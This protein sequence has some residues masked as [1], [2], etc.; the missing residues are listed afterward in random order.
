MR[1]GLNQAAYVIIKDWY[2]MCRSSTGAVWLST[3]SPIAEP[4]LFT[5][6]SRDQAQRHA[7]TH[8]ATVVPINQIRV[9]HA[10]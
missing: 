6:P 3:L 7:D 4:K 2:V 1:P 5:W 9:I 10:I 8:G